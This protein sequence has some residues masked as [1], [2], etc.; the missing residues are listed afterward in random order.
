MIYK[1]KQGSYKGLDAQRTG[2]ELERIRQVEGGTLPT[3]R[4]WTEARNEESPIHKAF[5]WDV[6]KAAE[7]RWADQARAL[8]R[9]VVVI[10][11]ESQTSAFINVSVKNEDVSEDAPTIH[12]YQAVQV[13]ASNPKEYESALAMSKSRLIAAQNGLDELLSLAKRKDKPRIRRAAK[14]VKSAVQQIAV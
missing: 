14:H 9:S 4:V 12:Y 10:Q 8:I 11:G 3:H 13:I 6:E 2:E 1:F 5:T 7:E